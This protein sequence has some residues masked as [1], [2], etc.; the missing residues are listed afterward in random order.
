MPVRL[1]G[2]HFLCILTYKG[3]GY[4]EPFIA[5]MDA[6]VQAIAAGQD[7]QLVIGPDDICAGFTEKCRQT[8]DHDCKAADTLRLDQLAIEAV[9]N[10]LQRDLSHA[11]PLTA[12]DIV[13]LRKAYTK[14][15][16]RAA[17][18]DCSWKSFCDDIADQGFAG[19]KL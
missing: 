18:T 11:T 8:V 15:T 12:I 5:N 16:I 7:V 2:H 14:G 6:R 9:S 19:T 17:C 13:T 10:I 4:S 1:R 3:A